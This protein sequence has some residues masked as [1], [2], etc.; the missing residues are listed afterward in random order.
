MGPAGAAGWGG[1]PAGVPSRSSQSQRIHPAPARTRDCILAWSWVEMTDT[2]SSVS[3]LPSATVQP[4]HRILRAVLSVLPGTQC[5]T[6]PYGPR[7][8]S[9]QASCDRTSAWLGRVLPGSPPYQE[10]A[11]VALALFRLEELAMVLAVLFKE[12][13]DIFIEMRLNPILW[14]LNFNSKKRVHALPS[15]KFKI[16]SIELLKLQLERLGSWDRCEIINEFSMEDEIV[17]VRFYEYYLLAVNL[18]I[19]MLFHPV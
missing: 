4:M 14:Q 1:Q 6:E 19:L 18:E 12:L 9:W 2:Q 5:R 10:R 13:R 16:C 17:S 7:T 11:Q 15:W 3:T 8:G